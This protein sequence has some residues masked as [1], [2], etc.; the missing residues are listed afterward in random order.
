MKGKKGKLYKGVLIIYTLLI[1]YKLYF[2]DESIDWIL[3][4]LDV[5]EKINL[6]NLPSSKQ[7]SSIHRE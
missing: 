5:V 3:E 1:L 4:C 7:S 6:L 2:N